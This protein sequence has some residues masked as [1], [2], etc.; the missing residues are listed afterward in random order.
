[1]KLMAPFLSVMAA[2]MR[3]L[4]LCMG[5]TNT[6]TSF[7][8]VAMSEMSAHMK[9]TRAFTSLTTDGER[10]DDRATSFMS[11][12]ANVHAPIMKAHDRARQPRDR[13]H[14][15]HGCPGLPARSR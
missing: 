2:A 11:V 5:F 8:I 10:L 15:P 1:M 7:V 13:G 12:P 14:E 3:L 6:G 4:G 9:L